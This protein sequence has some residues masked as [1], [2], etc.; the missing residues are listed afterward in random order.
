MLEVKPIQTKQEQKEICELCKV[1]F[2][3]DCLAYSAKEGE[4][5]LGVAQ[6]RIFGKRA[7]IYDIANAAE[8]DDFE[9]LVVLCKA[10]LNFLYLCKVGE[11]IVRTENKRLAKTLKLAQGS[12]GYRVDLKDCFKPGHC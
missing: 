11:A 2:D 1:E 7:V 9:V 5:L 3:P 8:T 12:D 4:R 10:A 6:F